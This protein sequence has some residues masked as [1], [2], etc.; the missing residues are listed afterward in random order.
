MNAGITRPTGLKLPAERRIGGFEQDFD[1]TTRQHRRYVAGAGRLRRS[2]GRI[3]ID[4]H[5]GRR[6]RKTGRREGRR[7]GIAGGD[8][9]PDMVEKNLLPDR[10]LTFRVSHGAIS[11][12][13]RHSIPALHIKFQLRTAHAVDGYSLAI[14]KRFDRSQ[15]KPS[16]PSFRPSARSMLAVAPMT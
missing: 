7:R 11:G 4:L 15:N 10:Q 6:G 5:R 3:G 1:I 8:K 16:L 2:P 12:R 13:I 14:T 9:M